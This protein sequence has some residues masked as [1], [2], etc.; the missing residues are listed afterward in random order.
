MPHHRHYDDSFG[1][2]RCGIFYYERHCRTTDSVFIGTWVFPSLLGDDIYF[3][4]DADHT[5]RASL[6]PAQEASS[7]FRG[8][9]FGGGSFLYFRRNT[10]D[11]DGF[12]TDHPLLIWRLESIS[13]NEL[14]V[15]LNPEGVPRTVRRASPESP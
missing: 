14:H 11:D 1:S 3:R 15:R 7:H 12:V 10:F 2:L 13:A 6:D 8:I 4:L 9:W 5:F